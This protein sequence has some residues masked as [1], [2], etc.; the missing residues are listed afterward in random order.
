[1]RKLA[2]Q[3]ANSFCYLVHWIDTGDVWGPFLYRGENATQEFVRRID[4]ELVRI[5]RVL[6]IKTD[7]IETKEDKK[8]FAK[9]DSC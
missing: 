7:R 6:V 9:A 8:K 2:E 4:K 3:K 1:M 5:N